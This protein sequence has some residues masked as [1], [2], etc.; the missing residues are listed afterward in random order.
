MSIVLP[1]PVATRVLLVDDDD[2]LR[3]SLRMTLTRD[4]RLNVVGDASD[5]AMLLRLLPDVPCE[6]ILLDLA[7]PGVDGLAVLLELQRTE[8]RVPVVVLSTHDDV[9]HVDRALALGA[10]GYVLKSSRVGDIVTA[11]R[12]AIDGGA[13]LDPSVARAMLDRHLVRSPAR[14]SSHGLSRRQLEVLEALCDGS[15]AYEVAQ[16]LALAESTV[17]VYIKQ[18]YSRL[19]VTSRA[20]AVAVAL[21]QGIVD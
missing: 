11:V 16:R 21:R 6:A 9:G 7:M 4:G 17:G 14:A 20:A 3:M 10:A 18:L 15:T 5:G 19:G 13:Y 1:P 8:S 2:D 12:C